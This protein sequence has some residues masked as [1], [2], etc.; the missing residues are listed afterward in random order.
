VRPR[1]SLAIALASVVAAGGVIG[2]LGDRTYALFSSQASNS[3]AGLSADT[4]WTP[5]SA[6]AAVVAKSTGGDAGYIRAGGNYYGYANVTD[7]GNPASGVA[8]VSADAGM[9]PIPFSSAGGPW[10]VDGVSYNYRTAVQTLQAG[11]PAGTYPFSLT[12]TDSDTPAN[13]QT[14]SGFNVVVDNTG[15]SASD[16]QT[17]NGG[18]TTYRPDL[19]DTVTFT[20]SEPVERNTILP[21]WTGATANVVVRIN[22][23]TGGNNDTLQ[24]YNSANTVLLPLTNATGLNLGRTDY[25]GTN[26]TFGATGTP[27]T[28]VRSGN[29][30]TITL[31]TQSGAGTTAAGN[32]TMAW[33]PSA[34]VTD[35]A[36]NAGSTALVN[37][38]G[39]ADREF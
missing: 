13:G 1:R 22:N 26:R 38:T 6:S 5:P 12:L 9:G 19:G 39:T 24:V 10:T 28:M 29:S 36:G 31:G 32:G 7:G 14:Q 4:D 17:A 35:R 30:I 37:E 25:V 20:Y 18:A 33:T 16:V 2:A 27:S 8:S 3:S 11:T 23:G 34:S 15:Q 21:T